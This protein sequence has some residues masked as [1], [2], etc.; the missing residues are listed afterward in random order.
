MTSVNE[1]ESAA[2]D[3][4][5][6]R[7]AAEPSAAEQATF[8][9][10][11]SAD[12][13]HRVAYLRLEKTWDRTE[14]LRDLR[15]LEGDIDAD[16]LSAHEQS[17]TRRGRRWLLLATAATVA[18]IAIGATTWI[19]LY[20]ASWQTFATDL[21][22]FSRILLEDGSTV[23][24]NTDSALSVR[25][26]GDTRQVTLVRGEARFKVAHD[27]QRPFEVEAAGA[28]VR[29]IGTSFT[30]RLRGTEQ[31]EVMVTEGRVA[32]AAA[33]GDLREYSPALPTISAGEAATVQSER[34]LVR[35]IDL[36]DITRR[37]AWTAGQLSFEG[38]TL[39]EA[40][41]EFNRYNRRQLR[42]VDS[43]IA[44]RRIGGSFDATDPDSFAAAL[45][46]TFGIRARAVNT[47]AGSSS[48]GQILLEGE[49]Q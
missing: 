6:R 13:R 46:T 43:A 30:V 29:A 15:P 25:M 4:F 38:E 19:S 32:I 17:M 47:E 7:D 40:V 18:A 12:I 8:D 34:V 11:L 22:G 49:K 26:T 44:Q 27:P 33:D 24:L 14:S 31:V 48:A 1:I 39:E 16:L 36:E 23:D 20:L 2:S 21:G 35:K 28:A 9:A 5:V 41:A 3:W 37:L 45:Q 10:W 42:I